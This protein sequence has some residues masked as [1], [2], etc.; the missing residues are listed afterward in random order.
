MTAVFPAEV[1]E[2][3]GPDAPAEVGVGWVAERFA[4]STSA[5]THA[6]RTGR[7]PSRA[8]PTSSGRFV[9]LVRP[10][11]AAVIWGHRLLSPPPAVA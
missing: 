5:V 10:A 1:A 4:V 7:L 8:I 2:A 9:Y 3:L 11:D 6:V